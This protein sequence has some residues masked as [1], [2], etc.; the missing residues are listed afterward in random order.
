MK[1]T[2]VGVV[3]VVGIAIAAVLVIQVLSAQPYQTPSET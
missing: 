2:V 1:L 3:L